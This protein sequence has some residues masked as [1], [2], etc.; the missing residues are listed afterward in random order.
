MDKLRA[1]VVGVGYLG[2]FHAQ[3]YAALP[4][5]ELVLIADSNLVRAAEISARLGGVRYVADLRE[6]IDGIDLVSVVVPPHKHFEIAAACLAAGIHALVEKPL[7]TTVEE[8][9]ALIDLA[10][11]R[12]LVLQVG[13][14]ERFNPAF[15]MLQGRVDAPVMLDA[16]RF[17]L[18]QARG[19]EVD[20]VLDLMIH[21]ID[22][23]LSLVRSDLTSVRAFG[24][25]IANDDIDAAVADLTF[26]NGCTARLRAD[27][28]CKQPARM[29]RVW[30]RD[31]VLTADF[32]EHTLATERRDD[33]G[34]R[35]ATVESCL[36]AMQPFG[37]DALLAEISAFVAAVRCGSSPQVSGDDGRRALRLAIEISQ[38]IKSNPTYRG[39]RLV[40]LRV[41]D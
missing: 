41:V 2:V 15:T 17:A 9:T 23:A 4:D 7:T 28:V 14:L 16:H 38:K 31:Q 36:G 12:G 24:Q 29:L 39:D 20:V 22:I 10:T 11:A 19:T 33:A 13:H 30:Q 26:A 40:P 32:M 21:D 8:A 34:A 1:A 37:R 5:V 35:E 3:K 27:R 18:P 25:R 6:A